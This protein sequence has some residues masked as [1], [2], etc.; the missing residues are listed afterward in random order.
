MKVAAWSIQ[1][2]EP[3]RIIPSTIALERHLEDWIERDPNLVAE[4]LEIV[5]RQVSVGAGRL[6]LL[7]VDPSGQYVV[8][9]LKP[10]TLY[11]D[12]VVQALD[13]AACV[14]A[15]PEASLRQI[16]SDYR[17]RHGKPET[18][19]AAAAAASPVAPSLEERDVS[20]IVVGCGKDAGLDRLLNFLGSKYE[21]PIRAVTFEV[22]ELSDGQR[23]LLREI[24]E[25]VPE[26]TVTKTPRTV[27]AVME[28]ARTNGFEA[29]MTQFLD[30]A[31]RHEIYARAWPSCI[32]FAPPANRTRCLFTAWP[33]SGGH[34]FYVSHEA[35]SEFY[36]FSGQ[37]MAR[38]L[39]A[40]GWHDLSDSVTTQMVSGLDELFRMAES[41]EKADAT[42]P[43]PM[44]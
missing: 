37:D 5:G 10:G 36:P 4:G 3:K 1:G 35:L 8:I 6:D 44:S 38:L 27:N 19:Q 17:Q 30:L 28:I 29:M 2:F 22:F 26:P 39:P 18:P 14:A 34:N 33:T 43:P 15:L 42:A 40:E 7:A 24:T 23:M 41:S 31:N 20:V 11:R 9:E 21:V 32:M 12:V 16:G 13:Y 25:K